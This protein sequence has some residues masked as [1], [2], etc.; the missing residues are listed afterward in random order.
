[1]SHLLP[2]EM[3]V[4]TRLLQTL[5]YLQ[6][7]HILII[8]RATLVIP[9]YNLTNKDRTLPPPALFFKQTICTVVKRKMI[10]QV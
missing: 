8:A 5:D 9:F 3:F 10:C 7:I 4:F 1:M 2:L 6:Y